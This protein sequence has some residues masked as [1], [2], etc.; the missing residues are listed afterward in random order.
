MPTI[1]CMSGYIGFGKTTCAKKL[2]EEYHAK[3]LTPDEVMIDLYGTDVKSDFMEKAEHVNEY[4]WRE[5]E[6]YIAAGQDVIYD[7]GPWGVAD[8]KYIMDR[9]SKL[10]ATVIWHQMECRIETAKRRTLERAKETGELS[11][12]SK[13]F[14]ENLKRYTPITEAEHLTVIYHKGE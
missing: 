4:I 6:K 5:I 13:F 10:N 14:D 9:A 3:R 2:A 8:R 7:S 12:D 1:H 11:I